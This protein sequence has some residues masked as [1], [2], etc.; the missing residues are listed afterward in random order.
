VG[1]LYFNIILREGIAPGVLLPVEFVGRG[2][3]RPE[4]LR[5]LVAISN[6][7]APPPVVSVFGLPRSRLVV[8]RNRVAPRA[9]TATWCL[10][11]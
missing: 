4:P 10:E 3:S 7:T 11:C 6:R 8:L 2:V 1:A 9:V 5:G